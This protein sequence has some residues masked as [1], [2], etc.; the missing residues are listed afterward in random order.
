MNRVYLNGFLIALQALR[1]DRSVAPFVIALLAAVPAFGQEPPAAA[2]HVDESL[3]RLSLQELMDVEVTSVSRQ[4]ERLREAPSAVQVVTNDDIR[5]SGA[6]RLPEALRLAGNLDVAQKNG[7]DWGISAR[8]FNT[9]L[10]NKLL[11]MIDGRTVYTPL[12]SGVIWNA[13]D[14]LLEDVDRIEVVSGPGASVWGANAVNGVISIITK[15]ARETQG[16][17]LEAGTGSVLESLFGARYGG[18]VGSGAYYRVYARGTDRGPEVFATG[19]PYADS[20]SKQQAG[21]RLD[22]TPSRRDEVTIQGDVYGG[23]GEV[24]N[25]LHTMSGRNLLARWIHTASVDSALNVQV[26]YDHTYLRQPAA[27]LV[28]NG[29]TLAPAGVFRDDL[30]TFDIDLQH[31]FR[32]GRS[33]SIV[34]GLGYRHTRDDVSNAPSLGIFPAHLSQNFYSGFVQGETALRAGVS[35]TLGTKVEH[36]DY[37]GFELEPGVRLQWERNARQTLWAAVSRAIRA[38]ARIDR[39]LSQGIPPYFVLLKGS[40]DFQSETLVAYEAGWRA[41]IGSSAD[42]SLSVFYNDYDD[43][44][45]A[46]FDPATAFPLTFHNDLEGNTLGTELAVTVRG[47]DWWRL[48]AA[49]AFLRGDLRVEPGGTDINNALNETADP[50]HRASIRASVDLPSR[51]ALDLM[52]RWV[53]RRPGHLGPAAAVLPAYAEADARLGWAVTDRLELSLVGH[54]LLHDHH[55][56]YGFDPAARAEVQRSVT[57]KAAWRF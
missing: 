23:H 44:R 55:A 35:L 32:A 51:V 22:M 17:Y 52:V 2:H 48:H 9:E 16:L 49:Y 24:P 50:E 40:P 41:R 11:V 12:F 18:R 28:I 10:A 21:F 27:A 39:D 42:G 20:W 14:A 6:T 53:D 38:P 37:T 56:E 36:T 45:S 5:R 26:Y 54:N 43:I 1:P 34:W 13:Q 19:A 8:G 3:K 7:H 46:A 25:G 15:S 30:D 29:T 47:G 4:P 33:S 31:R 57:G